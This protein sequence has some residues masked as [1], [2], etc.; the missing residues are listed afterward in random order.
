[1]VNLNQVVTGEVLST[2]ITP[3]FLTFDEFGYP[4]WDV[5]VAVAHPF[6]PVSPIAV[7]GGVFPFDFD[8]SHDGC[9]SVF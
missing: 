9:F 3:S 8:M 2:V 6:T 5:S 4:C 7:V 1:M